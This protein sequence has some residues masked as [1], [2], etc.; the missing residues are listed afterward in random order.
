[1]LEGLIGCSSERRADFVASW[2]A[3]RSTV[4][5]AAQGNSAREF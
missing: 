4:T 1:M 2:G 5:V 3:A